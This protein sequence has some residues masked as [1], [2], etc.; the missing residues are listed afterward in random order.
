VSSLDSLG[1][2][3]FFQEQSEFAQ[4]RMARVVEDQRG[5]CRVAGDFDGWAEVS[6]RFRH[7][8]NSAADLPAVGDWVGVAAEPGAERG[9][10][11]CRLK[12]RSTV[13]RRAAGRAVDE[14]VLAANVDTIFL[15]TALTG[16]LN[17]RRIERYLTMV[18]EAGAV[19]V[20]VLNKVD[21]CEDPS[22]AA[23]ATRA[24][25]PFVDVLSVSALTTD[26][27]DQLSPYLTR[28]TT[29]ALLGSSG[30]G[31]STLVNRLLGHDL[32]KVA[33]VSGDA[34]GRGRHTTTA[35]QLVEL[36]S[37]ALLIDTPGMRELQ[38]WVDE[39]A[40]DGAFEDIAQ[41]ARACRFS[42]CAHA[43]EPDCA[44]LEAVTAGTL[45]G[46]RLEHYRRLLREAAFEERKRDKSA[47]A[48]EKRRWRRINQ[49][50]KALYRQR[51]I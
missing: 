48:E 32:Q 44:V 46:S 45:D 11:H 7:Q 34:D 42:D 25:L 29:I 41:L 40:I 23:D 21:L 38:P 19:P 49:S 6:G 37:G 39:S 13:S 31:K 43:E 26:G 4:F 8:A 1:W 17:P 12:R 14:Q 15:V 2:N 24:R 22:A 5:L 47:A 35:R 9:V 27:L 30:V 16:D 51:D 36:A 50:L 33:A 3:S 10:I 20:V 18:W 28:G